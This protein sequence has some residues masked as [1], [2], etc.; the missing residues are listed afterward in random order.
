VEP[1]R[2]FESFQL[3]STYSLAAIFE[4]VSW[5]AWP[6][7]YFYVLCQLFPQLKIP[8]FRVFFVEDEIRI[9]YK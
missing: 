2:H 3:V 4:V 5:L 8:Q 1:G 6:S 7:G 9:V